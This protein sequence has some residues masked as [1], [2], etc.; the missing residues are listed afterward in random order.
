MDPLLVVDGLEKRFGGN[1]A[2]DGATFEVAAESITGLIGPNGAG[3]TTCF[4][5]IAGALKPDGGS[6]IFDGEDITGMPSYRVYERGLART[7]QIPQELGGMSVLENLM[8][9][10]LQQSGER[11]WESWFRPYR[12]GADPGRGV[13][14][15]MPAQRAT[16]EWRWRRV[17]PRARSVEVSDE[18][19]HQ[20]DGLLQVL[21]FGHA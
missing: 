16:D 7:F 14:V 6:V 1:R 2:V 18:R 15:I 13:A 20:L 9:A 17:T 10:P 4:N 19:G 12:S 3:K 11:V 21:R 5:C 8:L